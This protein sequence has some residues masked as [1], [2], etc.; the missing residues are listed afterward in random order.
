MS[1]GFEMAGN[2]GPAGITPILDQIEEELSR[3]MQVNAD[4]RSV[5]IDAAP[6][7]ELVRTGCDLVAGIRSPAESVT[8]GKTRADPAL[9]GET[10]SLLRHTYRRILVREYLPPATAREVLSVAQSF[11][12]AAGSMG[13]Y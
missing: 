7:E 4:L 13:I 1:P 6:V 8:P 10:V 2:G 9:L 5:S 12:K 3:A 11:D